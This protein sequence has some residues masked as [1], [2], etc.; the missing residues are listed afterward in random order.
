MKVRIVIG[1]VFILSLTFLSLGPARKIVKQDS[2][3]T[4]TSSEPIIIRPKKGDV[5][6]RPKLANGYPEEWDSM[7]FF[8]N[9]RLDTNVVRVTN[10]YAINDSLIVT[11]VQEYRTNK[12]WNT[13]AWED[14]SRAKVDQQIKYLYPEL[15][16]VI[17]ILGDFPAVRRSNRLFTGVYS[18]T[19]TMDNIRNRIESYLTHEEWNQDLNNDDWLQNQRFEIQKDI[20]E[21]LEAQRQALIGLYGEMPLPIFQRIMAVESGLTYKL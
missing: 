4:T 5:S 13:Q 7:E 17:D 20:H 9:Q 18:I 21:M 16:Q 11:N 19:F 15:A 12:Y 8:Y 6:G 1:V 2:M 3:D 10:V 14:F